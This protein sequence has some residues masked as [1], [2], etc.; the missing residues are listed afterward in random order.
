MINDTDTVLILR[1]T[2][3]HAIIELYRKVYLHLRRQ[4]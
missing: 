2:L 1:T 3:K 4:Y